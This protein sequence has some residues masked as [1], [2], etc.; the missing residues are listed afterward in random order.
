M[1]Y[2]EIREIPRRYPDVDLALLHLGGTKILGLVTVTMDATDGVKMMRI[3]LP[4]RAISIHFN[5]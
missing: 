5:D 3:I 4:R 1:V 2:G